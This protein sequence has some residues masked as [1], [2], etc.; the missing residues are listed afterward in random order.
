MNIILIRH[1]EVDIERNKLLDFSQYQDWEKQYD[2]ANIIVDQKS[3]SKQLAHISHLLEQNYVLLSSCLVRSI[4]TAENMFHAKPQSSQMF[5]EAYKSIGRLP[6]LTL[7]LKL[8]AKYWSF[9]Y[10]MLWLCHINLTATE[11]RKEFLLRVSNAA[12]RLIECAELHHTVILV[13]HYWLNKSVACQLK[14]RGWTLQQ[15]HQAESHW[16]I[17]CYCRP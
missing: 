15:A 14:R 5:N 17:Q 13:G 11:S 7:K 16:G 9:I 1:G 4:Q 6:A 3:C 12:T 2:R 8:K 10:R